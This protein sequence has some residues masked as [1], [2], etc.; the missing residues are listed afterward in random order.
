MKTTRVDF[1][2]QHAYPCVEGG[3]QHPVDQLA[4]NSPD[5]AERY[6]CRLCQAV[7]L[8]DGNIF[9]IQTM[10]R[11]VHVTCDMSGPIRVE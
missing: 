7:F 1:E 9:G 5:G 8:I 3:G 2:S 6:R 4:A 11:P 10:P